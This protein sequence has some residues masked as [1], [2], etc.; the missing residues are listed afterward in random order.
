M[1]Q[2]EPPFPRPRQRSPHERRLSTYEVPVEDATYDQNQE[3]DPDELRSFYIEARFSERKQYEQ[4]FVVRR[5]KL[6]STPHITIAFVTDTN[7]PK[8]RRFFRLVRGTASLKPS[9]IPI[10]SA[11]R[12]DNVWLVEDLGHVENV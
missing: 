2:K 6:L 3:R 4:R 5:F 11:S 10:A 7:A 1:P 9:E 12:R 8:Q